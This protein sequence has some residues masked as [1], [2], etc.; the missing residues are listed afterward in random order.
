MEEFPSVSYRF[1]LLASLSYKIESSLV[2]IEVGEYRLLFL[3]FLG[4]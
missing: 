4:E 3:L 1:R 2:F